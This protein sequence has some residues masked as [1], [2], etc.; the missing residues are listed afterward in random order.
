MAKMKGN[1]KEEG[2]RRI[3]M[4]MLLWEQWTEQGGGGCVVGVS[5]TD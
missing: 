2:K 5:R 4:R 3:E 1:R